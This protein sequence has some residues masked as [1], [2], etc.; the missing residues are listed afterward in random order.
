VA[1]YV[2]C[3]FACSELKRGVSWVYC[4]II[5]LSLSLSLLGISL[6]YFMA[7]CGGLAL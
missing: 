1:I 6:F 2:Y 4:T 3:R 5:S 7:V